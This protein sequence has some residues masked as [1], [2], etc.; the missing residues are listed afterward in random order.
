MM[1]YIA[2]ISF[3]D[4]RKI[5]LFCCD[6]ADLVNVVAGRVHL[7]GHEAD[8]HLVLDA[9]VCEGVE[10]PPARGLDLARDV[11]VLEDDVSALVLAA[12]PLQ[13]HLVAGGPQREGRV[14]VHSVQ[15][16]ELDLRR[17]HAYKSGDTW[18]QCW[19]RGS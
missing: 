18:H 4:S 11:E 6:C 7:L 10:P 2:H 14:L 17:R 12:P 1:K 13:V 3:S 5:F 15:D 8:H 19:S 9:V 16:L